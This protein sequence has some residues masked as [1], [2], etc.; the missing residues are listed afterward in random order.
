ML[1]KPE[2]QHAKEE[3]KTL[4]F[5]WMQVLKSQTPSGKRIPLGTYKKTSLAFL[6]GFLCFHGRALDQRTQASEDRYSGHYGKKER[7]SVHGFSHP[8][9]IPQRATR[10]PFLGEP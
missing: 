9:A 1:L 5:G 7:T 8:F 10:L 3:I 4:A 2:S 6:E